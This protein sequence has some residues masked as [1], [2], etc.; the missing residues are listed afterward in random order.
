MRRIIQVNMKESKIYDV[1]L[2]YNELELLKRRVLYL[3][4]SIEK[5]LVVNFNPKPIDFDHPKLSVLNYNKK[6]DFFGDNFLKRLLEKV[7]LKDV[8]PEDY[9]IFSKTFEIPDKTIFPTIKQFQSKKI[10]FLI[11]KNIFWKPEYVSDFKH[12]G[13]RIICV[14]NI[15]ENHKVQENYFHEKFLHAIEKSSLSCGWSLQGFQTDKDFYEHVQF[16]GP[17]PLRD[18]LPN[19]QMVKYYKENL[20]SFEHPNKISRLKIDLSPDIPIGFE[21]LSHN[22][23]VR[24]PQDVFICLEDFGIQIPNRV[25]YGNYDYE[26]FKEVYKKNEVLRILKDRNLFFTDKVHIK[27]KTELEYSVFTYLEISQGIP[28]DMF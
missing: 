18:K 19:Q 21:E 2:Y 5:F 26:T 25:L 16:W 27:E 11:N 9:L 8:R 10:T 13:N 7:E 22:F 1:V 4:D 12:S 28:S 6:I 23:N 3:E 17:E 20:L 24:E 15:L 14:T